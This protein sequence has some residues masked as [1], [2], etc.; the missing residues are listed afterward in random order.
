[1]YNLVQTGDVIEYVNN[2]T[3]AALVLF[4]GTEKSFLLFATTNPN[5]NPRSR[6]L[7]IEEHALL[8]YP[9]RRI[10][11]FAPVIRVNYFM[12]PTNKSF[13]EHRIKDLQKEFNVIPE[14]LIR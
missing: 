12:R 13:P 7:T 6:I 14:L 9:Q 5:W 11:Y 3:H 4:R 1:M 10:T 2:G 8:G